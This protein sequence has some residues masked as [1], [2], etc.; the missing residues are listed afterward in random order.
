MAHPW[1]YIQLRNTGQGFRADAMLYC[2]SAIEMFEKMKKEDI[3]KIAFE[4]ATKGM[5]GIDINNPS[6]R[7]TIKSMKGE[8]TGLQLI[9]YMYVGFKIITPEQ[10]VGI[11]LS[12]EYNAARQFLQHK[13]PSWN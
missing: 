2:Q 1:N 7:Y 12:R 3:Q 9:S 4:I 8:F 13:G 5:D 10:N 11:D 6:K